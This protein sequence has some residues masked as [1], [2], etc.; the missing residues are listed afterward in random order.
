MTRRKDPRSFITVHDD[1]MNHP[2]IKRL[3]DPAKVHLL[4]LWGYC[5]KFRTDGRV[6]TT[7][8]K[9]QGPKVFKEL[10][11][12]ATPFLETIEDPEY[13]FYCHDYLN[14]QW[15]KKEIEDEAAD[16]K[17]SGALGLHNRHHVNTGTF[18]PGCFHC[19]NPEQA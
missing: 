16:K 18:K 4:R 12:G 5:N 8:A 9:E 7:D 6:T 10:T 1:I 19:E 13:D 14:H 11:T 17:K 3:S 15:S 2:K